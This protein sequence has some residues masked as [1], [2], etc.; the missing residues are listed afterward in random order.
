[1]VR[2]LATL[3]RYDQQWFCWCS[4]R[5]QSFQQQRWIRVLSRTGDGHCYALIALLLGSTSA[6]PGNAFVLT[7][8]AG[9]SIEIPL[10]ILI[11]RWLKRPRPYQTLS[12]T[13]VIR[14]HDQFS[15]PSGHT[16]AAFLFAGIASSFY[17]AW[18]P[19]WM[20]WATGVGLSRILLGVHYPGDILAG[21]VLG[22]GL[23]FIALQ[24]IS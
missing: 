13:A 23:A 18:T 3:S 19:L 17:P 12:I 24:L 10:F 21:A 2:W 9:F 1:M 11:K 8:A 7:L 20:S 16:T 5:S 22:S 15:F 6:A 4:Q 14:A